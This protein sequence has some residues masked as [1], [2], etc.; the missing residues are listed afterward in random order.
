MVIVKLQLSFLTFCLNSCFSN[1]KFQCEIQNSK[2]EGTTSWKNCLKFM[3]SKA[4]WLCLVFLN[5]G[6]F[7]R[8][9]FAVSVL[10]F[11]GPVLTLLLSME[12]PI[13]PDPALWIRITW[14]RKLPPVTIF[15][16]SKLLC[17]ISVDNV[18]LCKAAQ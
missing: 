5:V 11:T 12:Y 13:A 15:T 10:H 8:N 2:R 17:H 9:T 7:I 6:A 1:I 14:Q 3:Q 16:T 4:T 18:L